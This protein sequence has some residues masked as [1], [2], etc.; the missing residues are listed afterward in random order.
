[1]TR[2]HSIY[3][4]TIG[5]GVFRST[6][7]GE[8]FKR[9]MDGGIFVESHVRAL[10]VHSNDPRTL[11][12]GTHQGLYRSTDGADSW[13][14]VE[15]PLNGRE[16]WSILLLPHDPDVIVVGAC[17][18]RLFV[19]WD[20]GRSWIEPAVTIRQECPRIIHTRVTCVAAADDRETLWAGV[21]IDGLCRSR[22]RGR[23]WQKAKLNSEQARYGWRHTALASVPYRVPTFELPDR[24]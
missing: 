11:Y 13:S 8:T 4:G 18:S 3:V 10:V 20:A 21:E 6:D 15:S 1:M 23:T 9:A 19:S 14:R 17:P 12:L 7:G 2:A 5:E 16:V 24:P 22:D